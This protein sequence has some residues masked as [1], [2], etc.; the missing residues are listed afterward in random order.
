M[1]G[2][3]FVIIFYLSFLFSMIGIY[4]GAMNY[5]KNNY[6]KYGNRV[7]FFDFSFVKIMRIIGFFSLLA[8]VASAF[9]VGQTP[10]HSLLYITAFLE[11]ESFF[12]FLYVIYHFIIAG[13]NFKRMT[14]KF[15]WKPP[16]GY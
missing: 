3:V 2:Y 10:K 9:F 4:I 7:I 15:T 13:K 1:L 14:G 16:E 12:L 5:A 8:A 6:T 11:I